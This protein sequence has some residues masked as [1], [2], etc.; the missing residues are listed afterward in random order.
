MAVA[1]SAYLNMGA[2]IPLQ[3]TAFTSFGFMLS[4]GIA[5]S[6]GSSVFKF[7]LLITTVNWGDVIFYCVCFLSFWCWGFNPGPCQCQEHALPLSYAQ[8]PYCGFDLSFPD[9]QW[10]WAYTCWS[11]V[12]LLRKF[13]CGLLT[14]FKSLSF[15]AVD[16][17]VFWIIN[18]FLV[19][20]IAH[21]YF[22]FF[23]RLSLYYVAS[24]AVQELLVW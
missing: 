10:S 15:F 9:D 6:Y 17:F 7:V 16:L 1:N 11:F 12:C 19:R 13:Y 2:Q 20:C 22:L 18:P 4:S 14:I 21:V 3:Y 5:R 24:I 8:P 23:N